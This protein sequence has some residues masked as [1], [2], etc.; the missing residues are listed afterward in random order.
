MSY[1]I[2]AFIGG[3]VIVT[4]LSFL[5]EKIIFQPLMDD[6]VKGKVGAVI[7]AWLASGTLAGFGMADGGP[8]KTM[9]YLLYLPSAIVVGIFFYR[10]G[11]ALRA[12]DAEAAEMERTF[13]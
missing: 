4:A 6:P 10:R 5:F 3:L 9:A 8:F 7:V 1:M 12:D 13:R 11:L 2:G